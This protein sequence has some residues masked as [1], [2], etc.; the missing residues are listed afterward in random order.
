VS[1]QPIRSDDLAELARALARGLAAGL[2]LSTACT[3]GADALPPASAAALR[4]SGKLL[5][6]GSG[7]SEAF[8]WAEE[9]D[10]GRV[11][12]GALAVHAELGGD[13]VATLSLAAEALAERERL[14]AEVEVA[15]AQAR[16]AARVVPIVPVAALALAAVLDPSALRPLAGTAAGGAILAIAA[17]LNAAGALLLRRMARCL[18]P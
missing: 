1:D 10:G 17:T 7:P 5:A 6:H 9:I 8:V 12:A 11:L 4:R 15:T 13:L 3:R 2:P 18:E 16:F 14:R